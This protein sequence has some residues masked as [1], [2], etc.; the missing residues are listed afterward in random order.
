HAHWNYGWALFNGADTASALKQW[1]IA[2]ELHSGNPS[3]VPTTMAVGLWLTGYNARAVEYYA[4]AVNS[5]PDRWS[6]AVDVAQATADW[7]ANEKLAI[8]A[9]HAAWR[10]SADASR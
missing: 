5:D 8:E 10:S 2:A 4:A 7:G 6:N 3:W 9:V 1:Q